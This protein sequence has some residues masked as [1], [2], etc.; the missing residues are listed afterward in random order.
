VRKISPLELAINSQKIGY[1]FSMQ[2]GM[3]KENVPDV[4]IDI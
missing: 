2:D 1:I 3:E 4:I